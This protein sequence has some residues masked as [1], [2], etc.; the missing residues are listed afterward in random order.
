MPS[1]G[2]TDLKARVA[3]RP[4][5]TLKQ[6]CRRYHRLE[7]FN[8]QPAFQSGIGQQ[9]AAGDACAQ[10]YD[11]CGL[12]FARVNKQGDQR[13]QTHVAQG[14]QGVAG[15][16]YALDVQTPERASGSRLFDHRDRTPRTL[17]VEQE[18]PASGMGKQRREPVPRQSQREPGN[19]DRQDGGLQRISETKAGLPRYGNAADQC[20][21]KS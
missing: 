13:L 9:C 7:Q 11:E 8:T 15:V 5:V 14:G 17:F 3:A 12:C 4:E 18:F 21:G 6:R 1:I 20:R 16:R 19:D 2:D 10:A